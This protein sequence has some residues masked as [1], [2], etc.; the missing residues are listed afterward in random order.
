VAGSLSGACKH[1][2]RVLNPGG[3]KILNP[4][5]PNTFFPSSPFNAAN[6]ASDGRLVVTDYSG[7]RISTVRDAA[8]SRRLPVLIRELPQEL[9]ASYAQSGSWPPAA[10]PILAQWRTVLLHGSDHSGAAARR[11]SIASS[12]CINS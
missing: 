1:F 2:W 6:L 8:A 11:S 12:G 3:W 10:E 7:R 4:A 5:G 9:W